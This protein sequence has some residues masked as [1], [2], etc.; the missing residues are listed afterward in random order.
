[1]KYIFLNLEMLSISFAYTL[2][3]QHYIIYKKKIVFS[4]G[5]PDEMSPHQPIFASPQLFSTDK[6]KINAELIQLTQKPL[7]YFLSI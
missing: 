2:F 6:Q 7:D 5:Y 1:M 3:Y 4:T